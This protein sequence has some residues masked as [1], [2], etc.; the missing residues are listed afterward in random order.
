MSTTK[1]IIDG[2]WKGERKCI[3]PKAGDADLWIE[4]WEDL[5]FLAKSGILV[6]V[7]HVKAHRTKKEKKEISQYEKFVTAGNEKADD[8]AKAGAMLD[9]GFMAEAR[10][11]TMQ[12]GREEVFS[13][14]QYAASLHCLVE[15][16]KDCEELRRQS[17]REK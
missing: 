9:E 5:H 4:I 1:G 3:N 16:G 10:A 7:E 2:L 13:A 17:P 12:Q 11:K 6:D 8:L 15:E 14:L